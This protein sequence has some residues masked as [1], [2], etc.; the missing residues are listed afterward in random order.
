[1]S[2]FNRCHQCGGWVPK[3]DAMCPHCNTAQ[4]AFRRAVA[5]LRPSKGAASRPGEEWNVSTTILGVLVFLFAA[6]LF[7]LGKQPD[8][9]VTSY[10]LRGDAEAAVLLGALTSI[11]GLDPFADGHWWRLVVPSFLH[12]GILHLGFNGSAL[13]QLGPR[14]QAGYGAGL[15]VAVFVLTG[16]SGFLA[17]HFL[18]PATIT[19]GASASVFGLLG[20]IMMN[21]WHV[22]DRESLRMYGGWIVGGIAIGFILPINHAAHFGGFVAGGLFAWLLPEHRVRLYPKLPALGAALG[23]ATALLS[24]AAI[25]RGAL[26]AKDLLSGG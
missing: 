17:S 13:A 14:V 12:F 21:A 8:F 3:Q 7:A 19:A 16:I 20:V 23:V 11:P 9:S 26:W 10:L 22:R 18:A 25:A 6:P 1:M 15:T 24:A 2:R 4:S 5:A